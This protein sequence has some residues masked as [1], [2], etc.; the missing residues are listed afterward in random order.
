MLTARVPRVVT[1]AGANRDSSGDSHEKKE[2]KEAS[3]L[4]LKAAGAQKSCMRVCRAR[5]TCSG[6]RC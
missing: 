5:A 3:K 1:Q 6:A 4:K 2:A